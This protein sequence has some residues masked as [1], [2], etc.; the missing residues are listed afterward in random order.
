MG[1]FY[2]YRFTKNHGFV[3]GNKRTARTT[4]C[5]FLDRNA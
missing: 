2:A 3:D 4:A 1:A 5:L